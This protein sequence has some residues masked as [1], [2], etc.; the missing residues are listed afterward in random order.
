MHA[1]LD[2]KE[3]WASDKREGKNFLSFSPFL[4]LSRELKGSEPW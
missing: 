3:N 1:Q 4:L 2:T